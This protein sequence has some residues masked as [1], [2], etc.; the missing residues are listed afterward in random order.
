MTTS[1]DDLEFQDAEV[2]ARYL[3]DHPNFLAER[4]E[5]LRELT[6]PARWNGDE[7]VDLQS[8]MLERLR[9]TI[10]DGTR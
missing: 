10:D 7:V 8:V 5:L 4:P 3:S 9:E 1:G 2:I 6:P